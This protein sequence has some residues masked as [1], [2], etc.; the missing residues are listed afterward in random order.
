[1]AA[2][3]S[4]QAFYRISKQHSDN[5]WLP[6]YRSEVTRPSAKDEQYYWKPLNT[7]LRG[8]CNAN[9]SRPLLIE[10]ISRTAENCLRAWMVDSAVSKS[11]SA[12]RCWKGSSFP[13]RNCSTGKWC[14]LG[15]FLIN[16]E[17]YGC[18]ID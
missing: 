5:T 15:M 6:V 9:V 11:R 10:V 8:L 7:R 3:K 17:S 4:A 13:D 1:M 12:S 14:D 18:R 16:S 2:T